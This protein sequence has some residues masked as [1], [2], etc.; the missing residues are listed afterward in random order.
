MQVVANGLRDP[1]GIIFDQ[2]GHLLIVEKEHG[3]SKLTLSDDDGPCVRAEGKA[4]VV[5]DDG[6]VS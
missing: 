2:E 1:R 6:S 5:I 3:V 4:E